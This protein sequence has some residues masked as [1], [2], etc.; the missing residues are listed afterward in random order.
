MGGVIPANLR[1]TSDTTYY[2][3]YS[4]LSTVEANWGLGSLGRG[5]TNKTMSNVFEFVANVTGYRNLDVRGADIPLTNITGTIP[6]PLS[7]FSSP[8]P[9]C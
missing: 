3:H 8:S 6:G 9:S 2:T 4:T 5:D 1:G 7:E